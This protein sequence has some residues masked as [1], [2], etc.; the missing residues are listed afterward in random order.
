MRSKGVD[1]HAQQFRQ[2]DLRIAARCFGRLHPTLGHFSTIFNFF[3]T[4]LER[5]ILLLLSLCLVAGGSTHVIDIVRGGFLPYDYVPFPINLFWTSLAVLDFTAAL[6]LWKRRNA[7]VL[8]T[9]AIM[10]ADVSINSYASYGLG[11]PFASFAPLQVQ[12]IFLGFVL[13]T[14]AFIWKSEPPNVLPNQ[15]FQPTPAARLN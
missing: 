4:A 11:I 10:C 2:P 6:L 14:S 5:A 1:S 3:M 7:G 9:M 15:T 8:L 13:G 12:S